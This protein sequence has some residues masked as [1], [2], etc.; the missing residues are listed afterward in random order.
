MVL[1]WM[2]LEVFRM[3][4]IKLNM[5]SVVVDIFLCSIPISSETSFTI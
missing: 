1:L 2:E 3:S 5:L 4:L